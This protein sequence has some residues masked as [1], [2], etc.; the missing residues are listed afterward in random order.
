MV[1]YDEKP[2]LSALFGLANRFGAIREHL[3]L[4]NKVTHFI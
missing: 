4:K 2:K 1:K 3:V